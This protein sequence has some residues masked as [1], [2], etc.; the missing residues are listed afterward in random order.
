[1][2]S[3]L[4][5]KDWWKRNDE[6]PLTFIKAAE[7]EEQR[8]KWRVLTI[9]RNFKSMPAYFISFEEKLAAL[10]D[11]TNSTRTE[12]QT[13]TQTI[14]NH[15]PPVYPQHNKT[16]TLKGR[17]KIKKLISLLLLKPNYQKI[18]SWNLTNSPAPLNHWH[19]WDIEWT[20]SDTEQH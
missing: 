15:L 4:L 2:T 17:E 1:M 16:S 9:W 14:N 19:Q 20:R 18:W 7:H 5:S 13:H 10:S 8:N 3:H 11:R 6:M 12:T